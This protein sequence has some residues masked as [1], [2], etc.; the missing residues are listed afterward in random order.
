MQYYEAVYLMKS[1]VHRLPQTPEE[2]PKRVLFLRQIKHFQ[3]LASTLLISTPEARVPIAN[4]TPIDGN[5][6]IF[7]GPRTMTDDENITP[8]ALPQPRNSRQDSMTAS[9]TRIKTVVAEIHKLVN[10]GNTKL[11]SALD[12][13]E[14]LSK[15]SIPAVLNDV[16]SLY[17][18]AAHLYLQAMQ[19]AEQ[20]STS[21]QEIQHVIS[22]IKSRLQSTLDRVEQLKSSGLKSS[23]IFHSSNNSRQD[24]A[25]SLTKKEIDVLKES[26][27]T[28]SGLFLPWS[29]V[30]ADAL[31]IE[32]SQAR[33]Q[34]ECIQRFTDPDGFLK[35]N[36]K[37][38]KVFYRWARPD[39][40][41]KL[42]HQKGTKKGNLQRPVLIHTINPYTI[43]QE[44]V[45]DCSF[46]AGLCVTAALERRLHTPV[47]TTS[48]YPQ[49]DDQ[50]PIYNLAGKYMVK[51]W[52]NGIARSVV[53]DDFLPIDKN[54]H[55]LCSHATESSSP[56]LELWVCLFEKAYM[57]LCGGYDFP[58]SNSG[59][60]LFSLT[61]W[62]PERV[63]FA[64]K[65]D[66]VRDF[67]TPPERAWQRISSANSFG[68]CVFTVS[69][70]LNLSEDDAERL[71][72]IT[73]HAY[74]VL[75]VIET[76]S[77]QRLLLLKNPWANKGWKGRFSPLDSV[78]D[79]DSLSK[80]VGYDAKRA[81]KKDDGVFYIAW[82]DVLKY[83]QN[84]HFSWNPFLFKYKTTV[85][86]LWSKDQGPFDDTFNVGE[87][88]QYLLQL[89]DQAIKKNAAVWVLV[90]R[91]VN[92]QEQAGAEASDYLTVPAY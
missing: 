78:W 34:P 13:D 52:L 45:T 23:K 39:E 32:A 70:H 84:V 87:N 85:H 77:G 15:D 35:L 12:R 8:N 36:K 86:A 82:E 79:D 20:I 72:L 27:M 71:G 58:G 14:A 11:A 31:N 26:S 62:I 67:E 47:I 41:V 73:G 61:G 29:E 48:L 16:V 92:K 3:Q 59:V 63:H 55:L 10:Q 6:G 19:L 33:H 50:Q 51:L 46:I 66:D 89:S 30:E 37:Q 42:R 88:P 4:A 44:F 76:Q 21:N 2:E 5:H 80:E 83:F 54:G 68:D 53:I 18:S 65:S 22:A 90:A 9:Q 74:A 69:S 24:P 7:L 56:L 43:K 64:K 49:G 28:V 91:H 81:Q 57:K 25:L 40:I 38:S 75:N 1:F 60:D 17:M